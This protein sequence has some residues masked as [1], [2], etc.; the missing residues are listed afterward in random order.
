MRYALQT[1]K[2]AIIHTVRKFKLVKCDETV[3]EDK[4]M[5][6]LIK[7]GFIGGFK[8]RVEKID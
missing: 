3:E 7:N 8:F 2:I 1:L 4:L 6:S 5:F